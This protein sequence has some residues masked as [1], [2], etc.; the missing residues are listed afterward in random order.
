MHSAPPRA[1]DLA[2]AILSQA[3][4]REASV[5]D[6]LAAALARHPGLPRRERALLLELVQGVKRWELR[7]DW[8]LSRLASRPLKKLHPLSLIILRVAAYQLLF[9]TRIPPRAALHEAG[10]QARA[11]RL[12]EA[13][14]GFINALL[15]TLLREGEPA[16]PS[17]K[18]DPVLALSI[19]HA[20]P[21]WLVGRWLER[22]GLQETADRLNANNR[23]PPLTIRA[24]SLKTDR[25]GLRVRLAEEGVQAV[26]GDWWV[27][28]LTLQAWET[29]PQELASFREGLWLFQDEAAM[30]AA[31]LL[32]LAPGMKVLEVGAG[33]GGKTTHLAER[34]GNQGMVAAVELHRRRLGQLTETLRR[35]GATVV[36]PLLADASRPLPFAPASFDAALIDAPCSGLGVIRRH[37]EI[38]TRLR[39]ADLASFPPRQRAMLEATAAML[40]PGGFLLYIT[41]TT[42][43]AENEDLMLAF[44]REHPE[45][46]LHP[47]TELPSTSLI[48]VIEPPGWFRTS[49]ARHNLDG[50]FAALLVKREKRDGKEPYSRSQ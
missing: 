37:P 26:P 24:N 23:L 46:R 49:P 38:K 40:R 15:R 9:L 13:Q 30:L 5:E 19:V 34:L 18:A 44:L 48:P 45:F 12:P 41:C 17:L 10:R 33:R 16:P 29:P 11:H 28:A 50:L 22:Y 20:H 14:A 25:E 1:R 8:A 21:P 42:E 32:P 39:E 4:R 47:L 6:L 2:V 31:A 27:T 36:Q 7:L 35:W 3:A 43:P